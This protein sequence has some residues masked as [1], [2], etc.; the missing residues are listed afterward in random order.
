MES[1]FLSTTFLV[2]SCVES[3]P[4]EY[5]YTT[6]TQAG[7]HGLGE[8][9]VQR[10]WEGTDGEGLAGHPWVSHIRCEEDTYTLSGV[11]YGGPIQIWVEKGVMDVNGKVLDVI[12]SSIWVNIGG[13]VRLGVKEETSVW[14]VGAPLDV[15]NGEQPRFVNYG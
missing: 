4:L 2:L 6:D 14:V 7:E 10:D 8:G 12:G 11:N 3:Q 5:F 15:R 9:C 1:V 13:E